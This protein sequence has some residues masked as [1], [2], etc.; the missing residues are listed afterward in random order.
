MQKTDKWSEQISFYRFLSNERV[1]EGDLIKTMREHCKSQCLDKRHL[2]LMEDTTELNMEKHRQRIHS[3][4]MLGLAGNNVD[5]GFFCH[6]TLVVDPAD[7]SLTGVIDTHLWHRQ[8]DKKDKNERDYR[9]LPFEDKESWRWAERAIASRRQLQEV[10]T[11]TVVQDREG[12][13]YESFCH[14]DR[15]NVNFVIRSAQNRLTPEGKLHDV[16]NAFPVLGKYCVTITTDNKKRKKREAILEVRYGTVEL[17]R[18]QNLTKEKA[19]GYP[20]TLSVQVVYVKEHVD[21]VP[22]GEEP[23]EWILYTSHPVNNLDDAQM[24][25]YWYTLRWLIEDLHRTLKSEGV[26]YESSELESGKALRKLLI[27]ALMAAV[28]ILQLRQARDG[29]TYQKP[30]LVFA[31]EQLAC[32][33]DLLPRLEGKTEKLKNPYPRNNLAWAAWIIAR[34]GGWKGYTSQR[35]PGV[36]IFREG[37]IRFQNIFEGWSMAKKCV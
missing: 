30:S 6:S 18:P 24:I 4:D 7:A 9:R 26:N 23:V 1:K 34:L 28:Q 5:L 16:I 22:D 35:P 13:I 3:K 36:I 29:N 20:P 27:L 2:L 31:N 33:E 12:D 11:I 21:S 37:W 15:S 17:N 32:M 14:L 25:L 10:E 19:K 8:E